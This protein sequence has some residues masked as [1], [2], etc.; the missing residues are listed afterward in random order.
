MPQNCSDFGSTTVGIPI[1]VYTIDSI[2]NVK[3]CK[4][5]E[6]STFF[7]NKNLILIEP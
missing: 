3:V 6:F 5:F 1:S 2:F 7:N 4:Y